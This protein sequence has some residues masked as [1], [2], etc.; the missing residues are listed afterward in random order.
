MKRDDRQ[1]L[2]ENLAIRPLVGLATDCDGLVPGPLVLDKL[3]VRGL[4]WVELGELVALIIGSDVKGGESLLP[5]NQEGTL[6][7]TVT[8]LAVD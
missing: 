8:R 1:L 2:L 7:R 5:A 3:A 6:D 4:A